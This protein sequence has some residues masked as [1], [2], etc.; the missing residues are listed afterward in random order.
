MNSDVFSIIT[1]EIENSRSF[2]E[3]I[4][5]VKKKNGLPIAVFEGADSFKTA[6]C[7]SLKNVSPAP[8]LIV[9]SEEKQARILKETLSAFLKN[10]FV[11]PAREFVFDPIE[12][13]SKDIEQERINI[14]SRLKNGECDIVI[15]VPDAIMQYTVPDD[16][17]NNSKITLTLGESNNINELISKLV[18]MGYKKCEVLEGSGQFSVRGSIVDIFS[19]AYDMPCRFD[20]FDDEIDSMGFF[21]VVDQ[22]RTE[23]VDKYIVVPVSE[24][25][26]IDF[27]A[28][29]AE[30][31]SMLQTASE[32]SRSVLEK[33]LSSI[34]NEKMLLGSDKYF[35]LIYKKKETILDYLKES[36]IVIFESKKV[37]ERIKA[38]EW[39]TNE[40]IGALVNKGIARYKNS[41]VFLHSNL[42]LS[43]IE[44]NVIV[45]DS[46]EAGEKLFDYK[47]V[48]FNQ[49]KSVSFNR[50][51]M[52]TLFESLKKWTSEKKK[53]LMAVRSEREAN[54]LSET[55]FDLGINVIPFSNNIFSG[56]V[57][58]AP[59]AKACNSGGFLN[60]DF[61]FVS[62]RGT[63]AEGAYSTSRKRSS[64]SKK[65]SE[66]ITSFTDLSVG[67]IVVHATFGI[68]RYC[69]VERIKSE[70]VYKDYIK[71]QYDGSDV[72][73]VPCSNLDMVS[74][75]IGDE[76][77]KL[78]KMGGADWHRKK[79]KAKSAA[80]DVAKDLIALYGERMLRTAH[81]FS[82]DDALQMEFEDLFEY[83]ETESQLEASRS[84]KNDMQSNVPM[85]RLLCGDVGFGKTEVAL[86]AAFKCVS[87]GKQVAIL[88][89]TTILALQHHQTI[90]Q[91]FRTFPIFSEM[92]SRF[93]TKAQQEEIIENLK[94]GKV[95]IV[96]G[97]HRLLQK[98]VSFKDLGLIIVDEE[99]RFGVKDKEKLKEISKNVHSLSLTATPIPRT[100]SMA[101]S[102][103]REMS[104]LDE[105]PMDRQ[106]IQTFVLEHDD[107]IIFEAI[108]RELRRG[109][110]VFYLHNRVDTIYAKAEKIRKE[111]PDKNIEVAHGQMNRSRLS[112]I[113]QNLVEGETDILICTTIIETGVDVPN[114]NTLIIEDA[115][116]M[117]I[118][119]LHQIR[120]RVGRS[121]R[122]AYA[123]LTYKSET[124]L[125]DIAQKRLEAIREYTEFG[126]GFRIAMRD[127][128]LRGAG[129]ILGT[130]QSG[131]MDAIGYE[132]Y[133]KIL[134]NAVLELKGEAIKEENDCTV[135]F[136]L[137][138]YVPESYITSDHTRMEI[139]KKI[140]EVN[141]DELYNDL[142]D[143]I[144]D[145]FGV[146]PKSVSNLIKIS[147]I[148][149]IARKYEVENIVQ[150]DEN[151]RIFLK[152]LHE[153]LPAFVCKADRCKG[154]IFFS[155]GEKPYFVLRLQKNEDILDIT[156][157]I[158]KLF[159]E[160]SEN[161]NK[162]S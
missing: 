56:V 95:D 32:V 142:I 2:S 130:S 102:G 41:E 22:R 91:R 71:I 120:G 12:S 97:T 106:P 161:L 147:L 115:N 36:K 132:L 72:L 146:P 86:R 160:F 103:I 63:K 74:K 87:E 65:K 100:L 138:A 89:P 114:A 105:A 31:N 75:Y 58:I 5:F 112:A 150:N 48:F 152:K 53:V 137:D 117:G 148:R 37:F 82:P 18:A 28:V 157:Y 67:D 141:S 46:F 26:G 4:K 153:D 44:K 98:D 14:I 49:S 140:A 69:G 8:L 93:K 145:R 24:V 108:R 21:D 111:F 45:W 135:S 83:V 84:I 151:I 29:V 70:K 10:V 50:F 54:I 96:V 42:F 7:A 154:R 6:F 133:V 80:S 55:V 39:T 30:I 128:E 119:Q 143:E 27:D 51:E 162:T 121:S 144:I 52:D 16:N 15:T 76:N 25:F 61:V 88:V 126:S 64:V 81:A 34:Q 19:P 33:E 3:I 13:Y 127:L 40:T 99:Q 139:Y 149:N 9:V 136:N 60:D 35:S 134:E 1:N 43:A 57:A 118:S 38:F 123:Y 107:E 85:E 113:W 101:I 47:K 131:H 20:F 23:N 11:Y 92:I 110:Q 79:N 62:D 17:F 104:V 77:V 66:S 155:N 159:T 116:R 59:S 129:N 122:K 124:N 94:Q 125:S 90:I 78:S 68:G 158:I 156:Q 109:G 73:F